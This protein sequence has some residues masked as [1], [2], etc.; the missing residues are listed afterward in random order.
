MYKPFFISYIHISFFHSPTKLWVLRI[1][2]TS[3][4]NTNW[5]ANIPPVTT[6]IQSLP[7]LQL[8]L[9]GLNGN[10]HLLL[11]SCFSDHRTG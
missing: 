6:S 11:K 10:G 5:G 9:S 4:V 7:I 1:V 8:E 3:A 2:T